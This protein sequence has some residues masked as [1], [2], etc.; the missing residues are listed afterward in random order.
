MTSQI[1][2]M[3]VLVD[4][5]LLADLEMRDGA[6]HEDGVPVDLVGLLELLAAEIALV[7]D[8]PPRFSFAAGRRS[9]AWTYSEEALEKAVRAAEALA[10]LYPLK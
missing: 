4:E 3:K 10:R 8:M 7:D 2:T 1:Y 9:V 6:W 5:T